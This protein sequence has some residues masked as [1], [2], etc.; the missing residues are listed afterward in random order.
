MITAE[1]KRICDKEIWSRA[2]GMWCGCR[3][4]APFNIDS[5][6]VCAGLDYCG[7]HIPPKGDARIYWDQIGVAK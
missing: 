1:G 2:A 4:P 3:K 7:E 6:Y 5:S